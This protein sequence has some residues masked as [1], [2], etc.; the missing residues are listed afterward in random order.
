MKIKKFA[1]LVVINAATQHTFIVKSQ[2]FKN[3]YYETLK[4]R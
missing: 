3:I 1:L 2:V 4:N